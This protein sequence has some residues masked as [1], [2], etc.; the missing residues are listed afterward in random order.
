MK[1]L[2]LAGDEMYVMICSR[3][4]LELCYD[5]LRVRIYGSALGASHG[6]RVAR[7]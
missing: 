2:R 1:P 7:F 6:C 4:L 5:L 3:I